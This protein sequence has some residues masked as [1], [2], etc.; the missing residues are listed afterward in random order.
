MFD[1]NK[2]DLTGSKKDK[3]NWKVSLMKG[4]SP[5]GTY[6]ALVTVIVIAIVIFL[7]L[8][9]GQLPSN[10]TEFDISDNSM[11]TVS[12]T[13]EEFL[14][15]LDQDIEI[16]VLSENT[17][18]H[19][20]KFIYSYAANSSHI[21]VKEIDPVMNPSILETYETVSDTVLVVNMETGKREAIQ[22]YGFDGYEE[23]LLL[24]DYDYYYNYGEYYA[25][26]FD[27]DGQVTSAINKTT[28]D[29][30]ETIY[31]L[32][33]HGESALG[34]SATDLI[35]KTNLSLN[36]VNL[37]SNGGVPEDCSFLICNNPTEDLADDELTILQ[38][39]LKAGGNVMLFIDDAELSNFSAL[40]AEY[41][42]EIQAGYVGDQ[43]RYNKTY[44]SQ[45]K[46]YCF[47]PVL[48]TDNEITASIS[49][50]ALI[51]Y[52]RG[53]L[54]SEP[55]RDTITT[56]AFLTTSESGINYI[57]DENIIEGTY[58][59]G[60]RAT[61]TTDSGVGSFTVISAV[62]LID[63]DIVSSFTNMSNLDIFMNAITT[64]FE[65][66]QS[67]AISSKSLVVSNNSLS[68]TGLWSLLFVVVVP[69][70]I[71]VGGFVFWLKRR[72]S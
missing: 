58:V 4:S 20:L 48:S 66:V 28:S 9:I 17:D 43:V 23:A 51:L 37:L 1:K 68:F 54:E 11:Y 3:K 61:E 57:D 53:M 39:Y 71:L 2:T 22:M 35:G 27:A 69:L 45:F 8:I 46:Y 56:T 15:N 24:Y 32:E 47:A 5:N 21:T 63:E 72:K 16:I 40:M 41:G 7:N 42:L 55:I 6:T 44:E 49:N 67:L 19:I 34:E 62:Y 30:S 36:S 14:Q 59:I 18:E 31:T 50:E 38:N 65:D 52:A 60:A 64:N 70:G 10:V 13:S 33:G 25:S 12:Y 29:I 26:A